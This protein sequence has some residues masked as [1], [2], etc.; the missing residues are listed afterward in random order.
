MMVGTRK[1]AGA[2]ASAVSTEMLIVGGGISG[3]LAAKN[4]AERG[5]PYLLVDREEILGGNWHSLSNNYSQLQA[6]EPM[7]RWDSQYKLDPNPLTKNSGQQVLDKLHEM[8]EDFEIPSHSW[9]HTEVV[10]IENSPRPTDNRSSKPNNNNKG[11]RFLALCKDVSTGE[12]RQVAC[13]FLCITCGI[14]TKQWTAEERGVKDLTKFKGIITFAGKHHGQDSAVGNTHLTGKQVVILG[15][16]AFAAEALEAADRQGAEHITVVSRPRYRWIIPFSRQFTITTICQAPLLPWSLKAAFAR[17]YI[18]HQ[19]YLPCNLEHTAPVG[20][21]SEVDFSGQCNDGYFRLAHQGKLT[22]ELGG[23]ERCEANHVVLNNEKYLP[24]DLLVV[25]AGCKYNLT[26]PFLQSLDVDFTDMHNYAFLGNNPRIGC[27]SDFVFAYVPEGPKK[28]L[29]M[30]FHSVDCC[31]KGLEDQIKQSLHPTP[32]P[33]HGSNGTDM[34]K[35]GRMAGHHT[36]F[37]YR[38]WW[39]WGSCAMEDRRTAWLRTMSVGRNWLATQGLKAKWDMT[40][41]GGW[42]GAALL[43]MVEVVKYPVYGKGVGDHHQRQRKGNGG[44]EENLKKNK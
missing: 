29:E 43:S 3:L 1:T 19:F 32:I 17:W 33:N 23:V 10:S 12:E 28:Q 34:H 30:F 16:G 2:S 27:A 42:C 37:E 38:H 39:S 6:F 26:P 36:F 24:C 35:G 31:R 8:A 20:K 13:D 5:I 40:A 41:V 4:C 18:K 22:C 44:T 11:P 25:A 9:M 15:S 14:I 21:P 7:Y